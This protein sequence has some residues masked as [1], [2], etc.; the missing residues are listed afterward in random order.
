MSRC[1]LAVAPLACLIVALP[2]AANERHFTR[3]HETAVLPPGTVEI[4]PMTTF[5]MGRD[6][7]FSR[8][9]NRLEFELGIADRWMSA[10][11]LNFS[12]SGTRGPD[13]SIDAPLEY[14]GVSSEWKVKL[15]DPVADPVG[16]ALYLEGTL[17]P[18]ELGIEGKVL[19]DKRVGDWGMVVNGAYEFEHALG[20]G[21]SE[22]KATVTAGVGWF[23]SPRMSLGLEAMSVNVLQDDAGGAGL[24]LQHGAV[25]AGPVVSYATQ[26]WWVALSVTPQ[27]LGYGAA[28]PSGRGLDL[29]E[30]ERVQ[31]RVLLGVHL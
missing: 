10:F 6:R 30:F 15:S 31:A 29:A 21:D 4:E 7:Y 20:G 16:S 18:G 28:V 8:I 5:R 12:A 26:G 3:S 1:H 22:H 24:K 13:G 23:L 14:G 11:Y 25:S 17:A 27:L 19:I 2:A 9:D